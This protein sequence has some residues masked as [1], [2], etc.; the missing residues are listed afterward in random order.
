M[1]QLSP[2]KVVTRTIAKN[3]SQWKSAANV[4]IIFAAIA[5]RNAGDFSAMKM[6]ATAVPMREAVMT[7]TSFFVAPVGRSTV[8]VAIAGV[9][10]TVVRTTAAMMQ[11]E[12]LGRGH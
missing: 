5:L 9:V 3:A 11:T 2:A 8:G 1:P 4:I 12:Y 7:A 6:F 10:R